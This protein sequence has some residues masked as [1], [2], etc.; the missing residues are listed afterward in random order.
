LEPEKDGY[1]FSVIRADLAFLGQHD[2]LLV[3]QV[4]TKTFG[5]DQNYCPAYISGVEYGGGIYRTRWGSF[6]PPVPRVRRPMLAVP[7]CQSK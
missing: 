3:I 4:Q 1:D 5:A 2:Q 6:N 7:L